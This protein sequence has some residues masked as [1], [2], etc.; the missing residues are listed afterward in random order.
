MLPILPI[1]K[2]RAGRDCGGNYDEC[3]TISGLNHSV[4]PQIELAFATILRGDRL[5]P[6]CGM[7]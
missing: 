6:E 4:F 3:V 2:F 7:E 5:S 1:K